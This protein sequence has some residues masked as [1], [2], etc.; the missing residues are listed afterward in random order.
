MTQVAEPGAAIGPSQVLLNQLCDGYLPRDF[1]IRYWD[2]STDG[3][4]SGHEA[5]FTLVLKHA[6]SLRQM[7]WPFNKAGI[8]EAYIY[9]DID[10]EGDILAFFD[11]LFHWRDRKFSALQR[12][13]L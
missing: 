8:G 5:R 2:G 10:I 4:D 9:D 3:P 1:A 11:L 6:G 12:L 7:L 13:G